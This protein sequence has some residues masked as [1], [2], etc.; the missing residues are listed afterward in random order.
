MPAADV[1][2]GKDENDNQVVRKVGKLPTFAFTPKSH[3]DL[4]L[5]L[6]L[7]DVKR[8][9]RIGGFRTYILKNQ[10]VLLEQALLNYALSLLVADGFTAMSAPSLVKQK[11]MWSTGYFPWGSQD[12]YRTQD[13][14][15]LAGTAEVAL[16]AFHAGETLLERDLPIKMVGI[17]P[18]FRQIGRAHV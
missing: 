13:E 11:T 9:V 7:L 5:A 4:M 8:A 17:S 14:Q 12:H 18:C 6:D 2:V 3:Q 10:A 16:T 15:I 1:P